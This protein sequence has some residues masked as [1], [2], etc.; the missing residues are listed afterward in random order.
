MA[1]EEKMVPVFLP[2]LADRLA[3]AE[4]DKGTPLTK[5]E[6]LAV[7]DRGTCV[8]LGESAILAMEKRRGFPDVDPEHCW[9]D[10]QKLR[11]KLAQKEKP[12]G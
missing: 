8:M 7:R 1:E 11:K 6:V 5:D 12:A 2:T 4:R 3:A 10:W 9:E